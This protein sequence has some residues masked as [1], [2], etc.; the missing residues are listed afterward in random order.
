MTQFC[1]NFFDIIRIIVNAEFHQILT[2]HKMFHRHTLIDQSCNRISIMRR[3]DHK[4]FS[5]LCQSADRLR[6]R[7]THTDNDTACPHL[8]RTKLS[9][10][11]VSQNHQIILLHTLFHHFRAG[12][13]D[14]HLSIRKMCMLI[15]NDHRS[16]YCFQN[17]AIRRSCLR[18]CCI[19]VNIHVRFC[20]VVCRDQTLQLLILIKDRKGKY[21]FIP[22]QRPCFFQRNFTVHSTDFTHIHV[23]DTR[24]DIRHIARC[25]HLKTFQHIQRFF[26]DLTGTLCLIN[27]IFLRSVF[28]IC[29][30]D[31]RTDRVRIR[32]LVSDHI[33]FPLIV[34]HNSLHMIIT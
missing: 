15:S 13:R 14:Q 21:I 19:V 11:T 25:I 16:I 8:D 26:V 28:D 3:T 1:H 31:R 27:G 32:I 2:G 34:F 6:N 20:N 29:I 9:F 12:C 5:L 23:F 4:T 22:H 17:V 33:N 24:T 10:I 30:S 18:K 7:N